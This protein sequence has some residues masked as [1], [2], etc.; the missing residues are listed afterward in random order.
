MAEAGRPCGP[1]GPCAGGP[2][3][4]R[5]T[6][7]PLLTRLAL[8][9][10]IEGGLTL[11][12]I[13]HARVDYA[14]LDNIVVW[15]EPASR[16]ATSPPPPQP[17]SVDVNPQKSSHGIDG[18]VTIGQKLIL[19]NAGPSPQSIYSVSDGNDFELSTVPSNGAGEYVVR[20]PGLIE[21]FADAS[22]DIAVQV[23]ATPTSW[24]QIGRSG[25][26]LD[27]NNIP[28][29]SY[30]IVSW[31]PRLPGS[32]QPVTLTADQVTDATIKVGVNSLPKVAEANR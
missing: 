1:A 13:G 2:L 26:T 3:R 5:R 19:K 23:F 22:K 28:P 4:A 15:V 8:R 21:I 9:V 18:V 31:H 10:P 30:Q 14:Q 11:V 7:W 27:F 24:A 29:G 6:L 25:Q 12:A 17:L 16:P 32:T 20:S